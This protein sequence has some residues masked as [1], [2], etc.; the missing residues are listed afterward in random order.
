MPTTPPSFF[1][2]RINEFNSWFDRV[3]GPQ[4]NLPT[5]EDIKVIIKFTVPR[6][7]TDVANLFF[8][9]PEDYDAS[10]NWADRLPYLSVPNGMGVDQKKL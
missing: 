8:P 9:E 1:L 5:P 10:G 3:F 7:K 6:L 4:K 2:T